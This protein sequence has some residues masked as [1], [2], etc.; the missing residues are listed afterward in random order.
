ME[1]INQLRADV[2][3]A[4]VELLEKGLVAGTWGNISVRC[5]KSRLVA[6][7]PSGRSYTT[8]TT[9]DIIIVDE[10]GTVVEGRW[11]PSTEL[12]LH[13][14]VYKARPDVRAVVHTHSIFASACA[15]ARK[16]IPPILEDLVQ[17]VGGAV[18][19]AEYATPGTER[20]AHNAVVALE[21]K[22]A[23]LLANHGV[24]GCGQSLREAMLACELVEKAGQ[25]YIYANQ[26]GGVTALS[27]ADV[28]ALH[29]FYRD[30]Y[31]KRQEGN[32]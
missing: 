11:K 19:V 9:D 16:A 21:G 29:E 31:S 18:E 2:V 10:H 17:V 5:S 4:G 26:L 22:N 27:E 8:L 32:E 6:V 23:V 1:T 15:V 14:A 12:P 28:A 30:H 7:S 25:I 13:L 3:A 24:I 20:L